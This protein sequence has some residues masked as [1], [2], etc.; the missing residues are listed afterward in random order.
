MRTQDER[1]VPTGS[2]PPWVPRAPRQPRLYLSISNR[3]RMHRISCRFFQ[4]PVENRWTSYESRL[5][6]PSVLQMVTP[7]A[8]REQIDR[9]PR[10]V[11]RVA[12]AEQNRGQCKVLIPRYQ[13]DDRLCEVS[14]QCLWICLRS[15]EGGPD[16]E[17]SS[18][19]AI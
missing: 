14:V 5:P 2:R 18:R 9:F 19:N 11:Q 10:P 3:T 12:G 6:G 4:F 15:C 17:H 7:R 16:T 8:G 13:V 1:G